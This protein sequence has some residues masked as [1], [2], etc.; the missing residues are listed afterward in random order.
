MKTLNAVIIFLI[1]FSLHMLF[2]DANAKEISIKDLEYKP[3]K[4][5]KQV[6][7]AKI[8]K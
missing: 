5:I 8:R 1:A 3:I 6:K 7:V 4:S 2:I